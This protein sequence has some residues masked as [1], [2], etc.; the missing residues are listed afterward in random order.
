MKNKSIVALL[1]VGTISTL[2]LKFIDHDETSMEAEDYKKGG[3]KNSYSQSKEEP[4]G[5]ELDP[6]LGKEKKPE[7]TDKKEEKPEAKKEE[8]K[9][10]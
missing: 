10:K 6:S 4:M 3:V 8:A 5:N 2:Q 7:K 1:L 9:V